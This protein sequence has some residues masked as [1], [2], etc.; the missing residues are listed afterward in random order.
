MP[1][2]VYD[3]TINL[4]KTAVEKARVGNSDKQHAIKQLSV[5]AQKIEK[6]FVP[7]PFFDEVVQRERDESYKHNGMTVFGKATPPKPKRPR[8]SDQLKLF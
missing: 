5:M 3:E 7:R 4:L 1:L 8:A 2:K 6:D